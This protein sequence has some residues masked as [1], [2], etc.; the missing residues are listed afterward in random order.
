MQARVEG[1][2]SHFLFKAGKVT[3]IKSV[4]QAILTYAMSTFKIPKGICGELDAVLRKFRRQSGPISTELAIKSWDSICQPKDRGGLGLR[5]FY[6][7]NMTLLA[8]LAWKLASG[9]ESLWTRILRARYL[10]GNSFF[11]CKAKKGGSYVWQR[12]F[13]ARK[14]IYRGACYKLGNGYHINPWC[15]P[16]IPSLEGFI[17]KA[18]VEIDTSSCRKVADFKMS[19]LND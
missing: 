13:A 3:F 15:D 14:F 18:K 17:P 19:G 5:K 8:K 6:D 9:D 11:E 4:A 1:W 2:N 10:K 12:I 16:W 7:V